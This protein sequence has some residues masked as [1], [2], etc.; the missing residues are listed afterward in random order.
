MKTYLFLFLTASFLISFQNS[1]AQDNFALIEKNAN[2]QANGL[3][4]DLN[5]TRDTLLLRSNKKINYVYSI[6]KSVKR[7]VSYT[8]NSKSFKVPL[9]GLSKGKH[10]F[11]AVLSPLRIVFVIRIL[12]DSK[13]EISLKENK[14]VATRNKD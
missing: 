11:V 3:F 7:E 2:I 5:K 13:I 14:V 6:N 4:H 9:K 1:N 8:V 10:V 12:Q